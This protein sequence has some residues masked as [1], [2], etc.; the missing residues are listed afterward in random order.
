MK[1]IRRKVKFIKTYVVGFGLFNESL[2]GW[3]YK[4]MFPIGTAVNRFMGSTDFS[5]CFQQ[6]AA[7]LGKASIFILLW[8]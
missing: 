2:N 6:T 3:G 1:I 4:P 7:G 8:I 5:R